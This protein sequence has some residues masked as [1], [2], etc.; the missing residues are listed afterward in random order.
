QSRRGGIGFGAFCRNK[1]ASVAGTNT[2]STSNPVDT[3]IESTE[4][5]PKMTD[6]EILLELSDAWRLAQ[7][8]KRS[9]FYTY[10]WPGTD[11]SPQDDG[12]SMPTSTPAVCLK[13]GRPQ[14][15]GLV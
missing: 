4:L 12:F 8:D 3:S 1:R 5:Q 7:A 6:Y 14:R 9:S 10:L 13:E 11:P 15:A 2:G